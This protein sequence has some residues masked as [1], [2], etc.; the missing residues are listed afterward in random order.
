[1]EWL[2]LSVLLVVAVYLAIQFPAFRKALGVC[3]ALLLILVAAGVAW[4]YGV[5]PV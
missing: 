2:F 3:L 4:M 1:M 5:A